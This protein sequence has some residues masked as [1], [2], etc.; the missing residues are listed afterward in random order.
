MENF[1]GVGLGHLT[2]AL[3]RERLFAHWMRYLLGSLLLFSCTRRDLIS[4]KGSD[5]VLPLSQAFAEKFLEK[6][7]DMLISVTG[8]GSGVGIAALMNGDADVAMSSRPLKLSERLKLAQRGKSLIEDT[9]AWDV[10]AI[11]VHPSNPVNRLTRA[12]L[13]DIYTGRIK[14][15]KEVGGLDMPILPYSRE[16]SSGTFEFFREHILRGQDFASEVRFIPATGM[17]VQSIAQTP[18]AIGYIGIAYV[19]SSVKPLSIAQDGDSTYY[20]PARTRA[21]LSRYP[22]ARPLYYYYDAQ[23]AERV[24]PFIQFVHS[25]QGRELVK[26]VGYVP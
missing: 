14:N 10:L 3:H 21:E 25:P 18:G 5:T 2:F 11:C 13:A 19:S 23:R 26:K 20:L 16:S 12:Q 1:L 17:M 15:W 6:N 8:G 9:I 7:S 4:V 24:K 22:I